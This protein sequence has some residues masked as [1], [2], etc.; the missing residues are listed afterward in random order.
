MGQAQKLEGR[1][2]AWNNIIARSFSEFKNIIRQLQLKSSKYI[3]SVSRININILSYSTLFTDD[4]SS[5]IL[6]LI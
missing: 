6:V 1:K 4:I 5:T 3:F 2:S